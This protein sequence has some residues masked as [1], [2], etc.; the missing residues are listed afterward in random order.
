MRRLIT[1]LTVA[2][3]TFKISVFVFYSLFGYGMAA[4]IPIEKARL[5]WQDDIAEAVFRYQI[6]HFSPGVERSVYYLSN[7]NDSDPSAWTMQE[8]QSDKLPVLRLSEIGMGDRSFSCHYC[9]DGEREFILR[10]GRVRWL[11]DNEALVG[12]S[13]RHWVGNVDKTFLFHVVRQRSR[14]VVRDCELL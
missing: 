12:G 5:R 14:W 9:P 6:E 7:S 4:L 3:L 13:L 11:N 8:M 10:V 1:R 2:F